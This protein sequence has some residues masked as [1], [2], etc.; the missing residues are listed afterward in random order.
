MWR[1][2]I[3][4]FIIGLMLGGFISLLFFRDR[5]AVKI[6]ATLM[7][8]LLISTRVLVFGYFPRLH[9]GWASYATVIVVAL[10]I[11]LPFSYWIGRLRKKD[12]QPTN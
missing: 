10:M 4:T 1:E 8:S 12:T 5:F 9:E 3:E 11:S 2:F 6:L 7:I